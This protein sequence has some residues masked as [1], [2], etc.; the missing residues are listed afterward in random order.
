MAVGGRASI[1]V[2]VISGCGGVLT[3][4]ANPISKR[5]S[6]DHFAIFTTRTYAANYDF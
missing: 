1:G 5:M 2:G 4:A 3:H 6:H